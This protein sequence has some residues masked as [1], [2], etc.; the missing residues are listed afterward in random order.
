MRLINK[1]D[2]NK[3]PAEIP[4]IFPYNFR[5][6][7]VTDSTMNMARK[8]CRDLA[9]WKKFILLIIPNEAMS[10]WNMGG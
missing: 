1:L 6:T 2:N 3:N 7:Y 8:G 5:P 9:I 10:K 4:A